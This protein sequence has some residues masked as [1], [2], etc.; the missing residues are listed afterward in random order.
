[1]IK[2][3]KIKCTSYGF[4]EQ[5][6]GLLSNGKY[7]YIRTR[8]T[9]AIIGIAESVDE[10]VDKAFCNPDGLIEY[11]DNDWRGSFTKGELQKL[12]KLA[13]VSFNENLYKLKQRFTLNNI[14]FELG[15]L[16]ERLINKFIKK[17]KIESKQLNLF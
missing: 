14:K 3:K 6:E 7:F 16:K 5:Y 2:V 11:E 13:D 9:R 17:N 1:M 10:A 4:P 8:F 15:C 12:F